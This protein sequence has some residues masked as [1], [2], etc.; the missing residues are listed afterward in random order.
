MIFASIR[1][2]AAQCWW[3]GRSRTIC[4]SGSAA[5]RWRAIAIC[6][7]APAEPDAYILFKPHPDVDAGHRAGRIDDADAL[8]LADRIVRDVPMPALLDA[9]DGVHV[10][11]SLTGFEA[12]LRGR[13]VTVHGSPFYAGWGLTRDLGPALPCRTR[14]LVID[15]LAAAALI[16]YPRYLDPVTGLL[17]PPEILV[18]R[19][20]GQAR[21]H[22]TPLIR[23]RRLQGWLRRTHVPIGRPA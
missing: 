4:R 12:L 1:A 6:S 13:D 17:C 20:A 11:T 16:L 19:L 23:A 3:R 9:V 2:G 7:P 21:P 5:A 10:L 22:Q 8:R 15:Q 14:R 18:G